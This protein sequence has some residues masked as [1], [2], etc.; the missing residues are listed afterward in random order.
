[1]ACD[2]AAQAYL[3]RRVLG[4]SERRWDAQSEDARRWALN[5]ALWVPANARAFREAEARREGK[6]AR[7]AARA[8]I[9]DISNLIDD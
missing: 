3:T 6:A 5:Q 7:K 8:R 9:G 2:G 1:M 4:L